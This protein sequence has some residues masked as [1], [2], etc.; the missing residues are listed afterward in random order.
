[1]TVGE[2][3]SA[4]ATS[5]SIRSTENVGT[6]RETSGKIAIKQNVGPI[7]RLNLQ[8]LNLLVKLSIN[9]ISK[10]IKCLLISYPISQ[11]KS[12][13]KNIL[14]PGG[15]KRDHVTSRDHV[16]KKSE[17]ITGDVDQKKKGEF[18]RGCGNAMFVV[19]MIT[20]AFYTQ[21]FHT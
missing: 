21:T 12:R 5:E 17:L 11:M 10:V 4:V 7:Q 20:L 9:K 16:T 8:R 13:C 18:V 6:H 1:M 2:V 14:P 15:T 3:T 19:G